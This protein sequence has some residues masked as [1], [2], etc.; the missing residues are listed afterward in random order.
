MKQ[1]TFLALVSP[2]LEYDTPAWSP[3]TQKD[4]NNIESVQRRAARFVCD[5]YRRVSSVTEMI[6]WL[7]WP[8]LQDHPADKDLEMSSKIEK[9]LVNIPFPE[10]LVK[11]HMNTRG[12]GR[13][14]IQIGGS[15]NAY[16]HSF[17]VR[18]VQKWNALPADAVEA[19]S[20]E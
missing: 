1:R 5:G 17:F 6:K 10:K 4:I 12:H 13:R 11:R 9:G 16:H 8:L 15:I 20:L 14:Y 3:H 19:D 18:T 2:T 7:H